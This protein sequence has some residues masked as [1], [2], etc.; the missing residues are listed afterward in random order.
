MAPMEMWSTHVTMFESIHDC[1]N[2]LINQ[3]YDFGFFFWF[4]KVIPTLIV[5]KREEE[6]IASLY[7]ACVPWMMLL[8]N[9]YKRSNVAKFSF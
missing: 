6:K 9:Q 7:A 8:L 1:F 3:I 4:L 5:L 2:D